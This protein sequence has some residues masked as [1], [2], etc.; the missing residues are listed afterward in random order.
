MP[1][2]TQYMLTVYTTINKHIYVYTTYLWLHIQS[3]SIQYNISM[4]T[5]T[6]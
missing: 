1:T 6:L 2:Y 5:Y 3:I 4:A